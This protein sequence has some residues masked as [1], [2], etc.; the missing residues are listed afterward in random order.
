PYTYVWTNKSSGAVVGNQY[1]V[2]NLDTGYYK[3][4]VRDSNLCELKDSIRVYSTGLPEIIIEQVTQ[5]TC[6]KSNGSATIAVREATQPIVYTWTPNPTGSTDST[7]SGVV[8]GTYQVKIR[9]VNGCEAMKS[10]EIGSYPDLVV[11]GTT[12]PEKCH[13]KDG[14]VSLSVTSGNP[15]SV[16]YVWTNSAGQVIDTTAHATSL[17]AG[18]Y[19]VMVKDTL[20]EAEQSFEITH[21]DGPKADFEASD[22][23]IATNRELR[24]TDESEGDLSSWLW[25][26]GDNS[27]DTGSEVSHAYGDAGE[28]SVLLQVTDEN[29]CMDTVSKVIQVYYKDLNV[30]I[31]NTF[32]PNGDGLNDTW[33]PIIS[34]YTKESYTISQMLIY[35]RWGQV[36]FHSEE[37]DAQWDGIADDGKIVAPNTVYAYIIILKNEAGYEYELTGHVFVLR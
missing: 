27:T 8:G 17:S 20:C 1:M 5:E 14:A 23:R 25:H 33:G 15:S 34:D 9:D 18:Q 28:Y 10:I 29:G 24:F 16:T 2:E 12:T 11:E 6:D 22:Y 35:D 13:R 4:V 30:F 31:P 19:R 21:I 37:P 32:T 36:I 7:L 3:V 26:F